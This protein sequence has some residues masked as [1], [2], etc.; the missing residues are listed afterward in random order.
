MILLCLIVYV[1]GEG[2]GG[3][4]LKKEKVMVEIGIV[5]KRF[6][7][8][9]LLRVIHTFNINPSFGDIR[10]ATFASMGPNTE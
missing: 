5:W 1:E 9:S 10:P 3:H 4:V 6:E 2:D 7:E 8:G